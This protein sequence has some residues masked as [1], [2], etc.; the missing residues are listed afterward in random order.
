MKRF[1]LAS[2]L[3]FAVSGARAE[4]TFQTGNNPQPNEAN[5]LFTLPDLGANIIGF[6]DHTGALVGFHSLTGQGLDQKAEGQAE[7]F[8]E[9]GTGC[10]FDSNS[11]PDLLTSIE[12]K[13]GPLAG[14]PTAWTDAIINLDSGV[15]DALVVVTD[16]AGASFE[17]TLKHGENFVT[18]TAAGGEVITDIQ[19]TEAPDNIGL[20]G[21]ESFKQPRVS[22]LCTIPTGST[23]C[24]EVP[25]PA[26]EPASML[27][28]G[29]GLLG[30]GWVRRRA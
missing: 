8:C 27:I 23:T 22:G 18:I 3:I 25:I 14:V 12:M 16:Q 17:T 24:T 15:G 26:P 4:I 6:V 11:L 30:L 21:F 5:I 2:V 7:I 29:M 10:L 20:F 13:A 9:P 1:L 28:L 19:V